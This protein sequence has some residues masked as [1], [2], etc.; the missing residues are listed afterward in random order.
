MNIYEL[1]NKKSHKKQKL[2]SEDSNMPVAVDSTSPIHGTTEGFDSIAD[3]NTVGFSVNS[4]EAYNAVMQ[5]FG[6]YINHDETSGIMYVPAEMW[7]KVESIAFD[8]DG[9]GAEQVDGYEQ[10]VAEGEL[11]EAVGGNYLYHATDSNGLK[12]ILQS[13]AIRAVNG[14]QMVTHAQT[15]MPTVSV[16]RDWGYASGSNASAQIQGGIGRAAILVLDRAAIESNYKTLGTSQSPIVTGLPYADKQDLKRAKIHKNQA[17]IDASIMKGISQSE[18]DNLIHKYNAPKFGGEFEE[19]IP[20]PKGSLPI[21]NILVGFWVNPKSELMKDPTIMSDP[22][23]L[24]MTGPNTFVNATAQNKEKR[25]AP[26]PA[27][28]ERQAEYRRMVQ[29]NKT[30]NAEQLANQG[31][32]EGWG[33]WS[34]PAHLQGTLDNLKADAIQRGGSGSALPGTK[35]GN[36]IQQTYNV[37]AWKNSKN[38]LP[39]VEELDVEA[40]Q[41]RAMA[42]EL[43]AEGYKVVEIHKQGVA[44]GFDKIQEVKKFRTTYGWAGG[45]KEP[46]EDKVAKHNSAVAKLPNG[47]AHRSNHPDLLKKAPKGYFFNISHKL[48][49]DQK[50]VAEVSDKTLKSYQQNVSSDSMKHKAD[51]TKRSPDKANRS[52]AGFAKA[53]NRLEKGVVKEEARIETIHGSA[54]TVDPDKYYVWAW[55]NAVVLYGEYTNENHAKLSLSKIERRATKRLGP[56]VKGR[57]EVASGKMLLSQYGGEQGV[58]EDSLNETEYPGQLDTSKLILKSIRHTGGDSHPGSPGYFDGPVYDNSGQYIGDLGFFPGGKLSSGNHSWS[59][60]A[61][62][63]VKNPRDPHLQDYWEKM[64]KNKIGYGN[65]PLDYKITDLNDPLMKQAIS[66]VEKLKQGVA[67]GSLNEGQYEM[68]MR[69]GQV[70]KFIAKDDADAKRIAAGHGAKS[71]IKLRGGVPA[72]KVAEQGVAEGWKQILRRLNPTRTKASILRKSQD[73]TNQGLDTIDQLAGMG[74]TSD[75]MVS[76]AM[77]PDTYFRNAARYAKLANKGVAEGERM[78]TASGMYRDQHTGVAYRGKTGQ[79]GNDSY[80]TPD[81]L[82]QKY[83]ERLAQIASGPYK[84][85]KEVAQLKSRIAKLQGQQGVAEDNLSEHDQQDSYDPRGEGEIHQ[86]YKVD[87]DPSARSYMIRKLHAAHGWGTA[88]LHLLSNEELVDEFK[89]L[90]NT[91]ELFGKLGIKEQGVSEGLDENILESRLYKMKL[92]GY[93]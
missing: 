56:A 12:G 77:K 19:A 26:T 73:Q 85:P 32:A 40:E 8:A 42:K 29:L 36:A 57:F 2:L 91:K 46:R 16:T 84:R 76:R 17:S 75:D 48:V 28:P 59:S 89:K 15:K 25:V 88:E 92:A 11:D 54:Y 58:A 30:Q 87:V 55:D 60:T 23:R 3:I 65:F 71:V 45:S 44:E 24:E 1:F 10:G 4:E 52:I 35:V 69:N 63:S 51:P 79:D 37:I 6:D 39:D 50:G 18:K 64:G 22:R 61:V 7:S 74:L 81:Y 21:K 49:P 70:K 72:G 78:K 62:L 66:Q 20:V 33:Y 14:P 43:K 80:M 31:V 83:Q 93:F 47:H 38:N 34:P 13:G 68:M 27:S 90:P 53:Q 86:S 41:A 5:H 82:I 67:E 9:V